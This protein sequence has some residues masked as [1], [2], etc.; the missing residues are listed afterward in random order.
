MEKNVLKLA[1][2]KIVNLLPRNWGWRIVIFI[3]LAIITT[4]IGF[5]VL[6]GIN[7]LR[8]P[9]MDITIYHSSTQ[10]IG[11]GDVIKLLSNKSNIRD[12][13]LGA[14]CHYAQMWIGYNYQED[15]SVPKFISTTG[16]N[17]RPL[18]NCSTCVGYLTSIRNDGKKTLE[19]I[20]IS[21]SFFDEDFILDDDSP[22]LRI[23]DEGRLLGDSGFK[24][25]IDKLESGESEVLPWSTKSFNDVSFNCKMNEKPSCPLITEDVA[26]IRNKHDA[27]NAFILLNVNPKDEEDIPYTDS[28]YHKF[29]FDWEENKFISDNYPGERWE[30]SFPID[31]IPQN[32]SQNPISELQFP[33]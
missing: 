15:D 18:R 25:V 10:N 19:N 2:K 28:K 30:K 6:F 23:E 12:I 9:T 20:K 13:Y 21:L 5:I 11:G 27:H 33:N 1:L 22:N 24:I 7:Y 29:I 14:G 16:Y 8:T 32:P 3:V 17:P 4:I 31:C 26:L